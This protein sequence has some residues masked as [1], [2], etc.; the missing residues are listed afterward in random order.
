MP[1]HRETRDI[2]ALTARIFWHLCSPP[3]GLARIGLL[4]PWVWCPFRRF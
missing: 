1:R 2:H 4:L 3:R